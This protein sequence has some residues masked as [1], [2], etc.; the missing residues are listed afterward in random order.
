MTRNNIL[1]LLRAGGRNVTIAE[2]E[3][4]RQQTNS[5]R[6]ES[7]LLK[8]LDAARAEAQAKA[9]PDAKAVGKTSAEQ[10]DTARPRGITREPTDAQLEEAPIERARVIA[11]MKRIRAGSP[12][13]PA[14][15][16]VRILRTKG[17]P[18]S[19][20]EVVSFQVL[21]APF[22][23]P[24]PPVREIRAELPPDPKP[25]SSPNQKSDPKQQSDPKSQSKPKRQPKPRQQL[26][27]RQQSSPKRKSNRKRKSREFAEDVCS[28][29]GVLV[30]L[31]GHCGC[32]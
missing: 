13:L 7:L 23:R 15:E 20:D 1:V 27:P 22:R 21:L 2:L 12:D 16:I 14:T 25:Q 26:K 10:K 19:I 32:S 31:N 4:A 3:R 18:L 6:E 8:A 11:E 29:C 17:I 28:A 30:S 9:E 24:A 5:T